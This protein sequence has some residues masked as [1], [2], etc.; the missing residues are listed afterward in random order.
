MAAAPDLDALA[1]LVSVAETGSIG[2]A[3]ARHD[4]TQPAVSLRLRA[5]ERQLR[6]TLLERSPSGSRLTGPGR[7][8]VDWARPLLD[9]AD[10][11]T[12]SVSALADRHHDRLRVAASLTVADHL[13]PGWLVALHAALPDVAVSLQAVNSEHVAE[14]VRAGDVDLGYLEGPEVPPGLRSRPVGG[15]E[16]VTVTAPAHPWA[17]RRRPVSPAELAAAPLVVREVGSGTRE[18]L[19]TALAGHGLSL[20]TGLELGSTAAIKAAVMA[21]EGPAVLSRLTVA[22]DLEAGRLVAIP[23]A[24]L[25]LR[26]RFRAVWRVGRA[27]TGPANT[28]LALSLRR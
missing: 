1:L 9:S 27:P 15:D 2:R 21:G 10:A 16:L 26:R 13:V 22:A 8:V 5:L 7:T 17:R 4:L 24:D 11:F 12:R 3:A 25:D 19:A 14:L 6:L 23:V 18:A 20:H 28:L